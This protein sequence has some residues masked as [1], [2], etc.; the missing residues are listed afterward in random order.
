MRNALVAGLAL[1]ALLAGC[2]EKE[3]IL[4][5]ERFDVRSPLDASI[6]TEGEPVPTDTAIENR[7]VPISLPSPVVNADWTH[8]GSNV[9]HLAPHVAL[10]AQPVRIW[11]AAIGEGNSRRNRIA[12]TPVVAGG[13]VFTLDL[14]G[15]KVRHGLAI[16]TGHHQIALITQLLVARG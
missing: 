11:T 15:G 1:A 3:V 2:A 12:T 8:R 5:G 13:R 10:S 9:R 16:G 6:P 4:P 14:K 7:S